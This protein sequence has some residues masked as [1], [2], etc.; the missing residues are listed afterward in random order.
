MQDKEH[1]RKSIALQEEAETRRKKDL[2]EKQ[3]QNKRRCV[4][5]VVAAA[6]RDIDHERQEHQKRSLEMWNQIVSKSMDAQ[7]L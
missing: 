5:A 6:E 2:L 4:A 1:E 7:P 3:E